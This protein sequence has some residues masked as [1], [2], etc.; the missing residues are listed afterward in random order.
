MMKTKKIKKM[1]INNAKLICA[2]LAVISLSGCAR[3]SMNIQD[4]NALRQLRQN[5]AIVTPIVTKPKE[6]KATVAA[7]G[8]RVT[9]MILAG[10]L[11][12]GVIG[13]VTENKE[14]RRLALEDHIQDPGE[15]A[16]PWLVRVLSQKD[17]DLRFSPIQELSNERTPS[18]SE[19]GDRT[20][21][22]TSSNGWHL[23]YYPFSTSKYRVIFQITAR[24]ISTKTHR[25]LWK[26]SCN[27]KG[28]ED[29]T[30]APSLDQYTANQGALIKSDISK[31][32]AF[33]A[34]MLAN[35][36]MAAY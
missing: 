1:K 4:S 13:E 29:K 34:T 21:L 11:L 7:Y 22:V 15:I 31:G 17:Q 24:L 16:L 32:S 5:H 35:K 2:T 33:C 20:V 30:N 12:G 36:L 3:V 26:A 28:N 6:P 10:P 23:M 8:K 9:S 27:Y 19:N 14:G 18:V 25:V